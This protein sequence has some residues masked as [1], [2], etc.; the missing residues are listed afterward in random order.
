MK[1]RLELG[2]ARQETSDRVI[3]AA[4][5]IAQRVGNLL[6]ARLAHAARD[7][8]FAGRVRAVP[9]RVIRVRH[10]RRSSWGH[11]VKEKITDGIADDVLRGATGF[12]Q[13]C[14]LASGRIDSVGLLASHR[15]AIDRENP[16]LNAYI[17]LD[18]GAFAAAAASAARRREGHVIG[19][20]DGLPVAI[21]DNLD[22]AGMPTRA[23]LPGRRR[24][25][26]DDAV[27]VARLRA[28]GAIILGKT[29]LDEGALG[30]T[31]ANLH[32]GPAQN[33]ARLGYTPGGSSGGSA[34]AVA[35]GLATFALG[36]DTLGSVRIPASHC[37]IYALK[38]TLG[39]ISTTG[40]LHGARRLD[41]VGILARSV[42]DLAIVM[43]VLD[44]FDPADPRSRRRRVPLATPDWEPGRLCAGFL[45]DLDAVGVAPAVRTLFESAIAALG[46]ELGEHRPV[47]FSDYDFARMRRAALLVME[48]E[49]AVEL[50]DDLSDGTYPF[51]PRLRAMLDYA[52]GKSAIDYAKADRQLDAG[53]LK[54]RRVFADVDVLVLPT[55]AHGPY[56]LADGERA[57]DA[58]LTS[59]A[60][61]AGCP[62]VTLPM[63]RLPDGLPAGLQLVG[64][65]G[66]DL[67]LLELA[68]ICAA[69]LDATPTYPVTG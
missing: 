64:P 63:G 12:Q 43:Q 15:A 51:S 28:A 7:A 66:S 1:A 49:L 24:V 56:P 32:T 26:I 8:R 4:D 5:F 6:I 40:M 48:S 59:F 21:K 60:S 47:D 3:A 36:T 61:I 42:P 31:S 29:Q 53:V 2:F 41:C 19:R 46:N 11:P 37:G 14:W 18:D 62:A 10:N 13:L 68:E 52:R 55:V 20:L 16:R 30:T 34:A 58:D 38:P 22:V 23:G 39:E 9:F 67:R 54:A 57:N 17:D 45:P 44:G 65:P 50:E 69:T 27:A 25:A 33:P 35:A